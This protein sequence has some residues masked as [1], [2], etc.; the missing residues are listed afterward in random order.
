MPSLTADVA[1]EEGSEGG[2]SRAEAGAEAGAGA[3]VQAATRDAAHLVD[4]DVLILARGGKD[5]GDVEVTVVEERGISM[6]S[7]IE[8]GGM[9][10]TPA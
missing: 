5:G 4:V 1:L 7:A 10:S 3:V 8:E 6:P 2:E 9:I